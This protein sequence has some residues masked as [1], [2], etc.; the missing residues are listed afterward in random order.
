MQI[1]RKV[2]D[3]QTNKTTQSGMAC[4][5][6]ALDIGHRIYSFHQEKQTGRVKMLCRDRPGKF[7]TL[8]SHINLDFTFLYYKII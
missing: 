5:V 3:C 8:Y 7:T 1:K 6:K 2:N 4:F